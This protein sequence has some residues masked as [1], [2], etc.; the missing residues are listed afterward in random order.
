[1]K[2]IRLIAFFFFLVVSTG[3]LVCQGT[4]L[5]KD[6]SLDYSAGYDGDLNNSLK[7]TLP[8]MEVPFMFL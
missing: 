8:F 2:N 6:L 5:F 3:T 1:M 7:L 4:T